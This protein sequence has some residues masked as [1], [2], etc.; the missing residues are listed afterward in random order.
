[1]EVTHIAS[2][3]IWHK[4]AKRKQTSEKHLILTEEKHINL[5]V[6][7]TLLYTSRNVKI[8]NKFNINK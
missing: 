4:C 3:I 2:Q 1:M 6:V 8:F 7:H 5:T